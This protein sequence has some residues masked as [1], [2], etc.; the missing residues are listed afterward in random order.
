MLESLHAWGH[1]DPLKY[2]ARQIV[3]W[4]SVASRR[5]LRERAAFTSDVFMGCNS[6]D[7]KKLNQYISELEDHG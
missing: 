6:V 5:I 1:A 4:Y 7:G 2:S 3:V